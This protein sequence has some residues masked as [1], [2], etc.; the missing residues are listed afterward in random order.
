MQKGSLRSVGI[1]I[2]INCPLGGNMSLKLSGIISGESTVSKHFV[3]LFCV[4]TTFKK[5][6]LFVAVGPKKQAAHVCIE[7]FL[8]VFNLDSIRNKLKDNRF[9]CVNC[10]L[11]KI[12]ALKIISVESIT[13]LQ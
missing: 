1:N 11:K 8:N 13:S 9:C 12:D 2:F 3:L 10:N 6:C 7:S 4:N 5:V